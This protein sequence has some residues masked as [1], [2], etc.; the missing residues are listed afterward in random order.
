MNIQ[1]GVA[2][3]LLHSRIEKLKLR[4]SNDLL[5]IVTV[6]LF[7]FYELDATSTLTRWS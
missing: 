6:S 2:V 1:F 3:M 7:M 4:K 5:S